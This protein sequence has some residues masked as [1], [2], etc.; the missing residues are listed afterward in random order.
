MPKM[1]DVDIDNERILKEYIE[2]TIYQMVEEDK[3]KDEYI[4]QVQNMQNIIS[5]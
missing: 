5:S 1:L 4:L 2:G 3:M